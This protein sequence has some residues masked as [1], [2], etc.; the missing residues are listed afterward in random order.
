MSRQSLQQQTCTSWFDWK[1]GWF[2]NK[3]HYAYF[4]L[5]KKNPISFPFCWWFRA[6]FTDIIHWARIPGEPLNHGQ[7]LRLQSKWLQTAEIGF[8]KF[9]ILARN[10]GSFILI[11]SLGVGLKVLL[12]LPHRI[13]I[14]V[15]VAA[16][17][18]WALLLWQ[19]AG[20]SWNAVEHWL[21]RRASMRKKQPLY[22][23][24]RTSWNL[25]FIAPLFIG[26]DT[27]TFREQGSQDWGLELSREKSRH[28]GPIASSLLRVHGNGAEPS[29]GGGPPPSSLAIIA[30]FSIG[31]QIVLPRLCWLEGHGASGQQSP[32]GK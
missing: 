4:C 29:G 30:A 10:A 9:S 19:V 31:T 8:W 6:K 12:S 18:F 1:L 14:K 25:V 15:S 2:L 13:N 21:Q 16:V 23:W 32:Q 28:R 11:S 22:V 7:V 27:L 17:C 5:L 20:C 3:L 24:E 26:M